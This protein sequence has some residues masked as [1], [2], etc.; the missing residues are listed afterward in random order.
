MTTNKKRS[1]E[2]QAEVQR[3]QE[4]ER[5][6]THARHL[7]RA[8]YA[9]ASEVGVAVERQP[10]ECLSDFA[11]RAVGQ[12]QGRFVE[13]KVALKSIEIHCRANERVLAEHSDLVS[14]S[15]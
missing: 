2:Q 1:K 8:I 4:I 7:E 15:V 9:A 10:D 12:V 5:A 6:N 3:Q 14:M 13:S 11:F